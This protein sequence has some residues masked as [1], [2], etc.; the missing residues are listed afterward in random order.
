[1]II[2]KLTKKLLIFYVEKAATSE[3][4]IPRYELHNLTD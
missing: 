2:L 3:Q 1:M 4:V